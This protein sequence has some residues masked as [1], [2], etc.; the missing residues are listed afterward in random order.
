MKKFTLALLIL[1]MSKVVWSQDLSANDLMTRMSCSVCH[2]E[3]SKVVGPSFNQIASRYPS[4]KSSVT[5]LANKIISGGVGTWG[6]IPMP[7]QRGLSIDQA[8]ILA[9]FIL[10]YQL[11]E[12]ILNPNQIKTNRTDSTSVSNTQI[13]SSHGDSDI[14]KAK[15]KCKELGFKEKTEAF[16]TCVLTLIKN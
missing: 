15:G 14:E 5:M 12:K 3:A 7:A 6:P 8:E 11:P 13:K 2:A 9:A 16:G 10:N 1:V 4:T